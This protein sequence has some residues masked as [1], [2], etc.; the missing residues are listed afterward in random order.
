MR[1]YHVRICERLGVKLPGPTRHPFAGL[2]AD[3][4]GVLYGTTQGASPGCHDNTTCGTAFRLTPPSTGQTEWTETVLY[5]FCSLPN[6]AD[7]G[8]P[9][10]GL[11]ADKQGVLYGTTQ[12]GGAT[13]QG[14]VFK[15][16]PPA[17]GQTEWTE[18]VIYSFCSLP[19]CSDGARPFNGRLFADKHGALYSTTQFGGAAGQGTVFKLTPPARF[20]TEWTET[21]LY[22]FCSLSNCSDGANPLG[23]TLIADNQGGFFGTTVAGGAAGQG[24]VFKLTPP[25][26]FETEWT[27]AVLYSFC[28][29]PNCSD[30]PSPTAGVITDKHGALYSTTY[31]GGGAA[32]SGTVFKLTPPA[33]YE[34]EWTEIVLHS[35]AGRPNDGAHSQLGLIADKHGALYGA[36]LNGGANNLGTVFKLTPP[37]RFQTEWTETMLYKFCSLPNCSDGAFSVGDLIPDKHGAL[38]GATLGG[39]AAGH[40]VVFKLSRAF[41]EKANRD[42]PE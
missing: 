4:Q 28:S 24:T 30:G 20:Q 18:T 15:L 14:T 32:D 8:R 33:K 40:G 23:T 21:V 17:K 22:S 26:R 6:C 1:E 13:D 37:A 31:N 11:I 39:G 27:A 12:F 9:L 25:A 42:P 3:K 2:I 16:M 34:T 19:N 41:G 29:L 5:Q 10:A 35:F 36:T 7:G 38:Y